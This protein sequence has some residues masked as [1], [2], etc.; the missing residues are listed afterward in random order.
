VQTAGEARVQLAPWAGGILLVISAV[1]C[2]RGEY[3]DPRPPEELGDDGVVY[4]P[5]LPSTINVPMTIPVASLVKLVDDVVPRRY[6]SLDELHDAAGNGRARVAFELERSPFHADFFG[7]IAR[8]SA[9]VLYRVRVRYNLPL[10]PDIEGTCGVGDDPRPAL[11]VS[12]ESPL[13]LTRGWSLRTKARVAYLGVASPQD[14]DRCTV[15]MAG[16]DITDRI[17][18]EA[19]TLLEEQLPQIDSLVASLD[20]R[21]RFASWWDTLREPIELSDSLW[22]AMGPESITRG[23]LRG[24][25][26]SVIVQLGLRSRPEIVFGGRPALPQT[27][28][29]PLDFGTVEPGF[30]L[31]VDARAEYGAATHFLQRALAGRR[32]DMGEHSVQVDSLE[33]YGIGSGRLAMSLR[34]SGDLR[35]RLYLTGRPAI[36]P[37]TGEASVPDLELDVA[38]RDLVSS[39]ASWFVAPVLRDYL[40]ERATWPTAPAGDWLAMWLKRGLNRNISGELRVAGTVSGVEIIGATALQDALW[41]RMAAHGSATMFVDD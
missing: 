26:D 4:A 35:G 9:T 12:I 34:V 17:I 23:D 38:S 39:A 15:T 31:R 5:P 30:E 33:V 40:R 16:I 3:L 37:A 8:L 1:A 41:V 28:L 13:S 18:A 36:D 10:L 21:S 32:I 20:T 19:R 24:S 27:P 22:L 2:G 14:M 25:G 29:P 11:T 7:D 6:G